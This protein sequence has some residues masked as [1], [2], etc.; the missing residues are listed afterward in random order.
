MTITCPEC[1]SRFKVGAETVGKKAKCGE[2]QHVFVVSNRTEQEETTASHHAS[3][4]SAK[5]FAGSSLYLAG[6]AAL[7]LLFRGGLGGLIATLVLALAVE[8]AS[9]YL[10]YRGWRDARQALQLQPSSHLARTG[11]LA[12]GVLLGLLAFSALLTVYQIITPSSQGIPGIG[13]LMKQLGGRNDLLK[14][15]S[16]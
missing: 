12:N 8:S 9:L 15:L 16:Q 10:A 4:P 13:D 11:L 1:A 2:C 7:L 3:T 6:L 14:G 5:E